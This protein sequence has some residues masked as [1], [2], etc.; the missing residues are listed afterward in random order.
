MRI[1]TAISSAQILGVFD[2][3]DE[4]KIRF[5]VEGAGPSNVIQIRARLLGQPSFT[6]LDTI[7][8][9]ENK[10]INV[11]T[12]E[13]LQIEC[14][15][16]DAISE[17]IKIYSASF[18]EAGGSAIDFIG[19]PSGSNLTDFNSFTFDSS[20]NS[21]TITGDN[22]TKTIDL[23]ANVA[24][25]G[26]TPDTPADWS[27]APTTVSEGL[28]Q[29]AE[30]MIDVEA[31]KI[32]STEKGAANGVA[33]LNALSKIDSTYLP[34]YVDD[35]EEYA[36]LAAFP[37]TGEASKI[38]VALDTNKTYRWA[39]TVYVE[40]SPSA[41]TSVNGQTGIVVLAKS[42]V[43][44]GNVDNT[45]DADK[46][47]STATQDALDLKY[48][49][50]NPAGY[51]TL[52]EV[53]AAP[54]TSVNS[55]VG[56][57]VL[58]KSDVGLGNVDNTSDADKPISTATQT[59]LDDKVAKAGDTMTGQL[60]MQDSAIVVDYTATSGFA[61]TTELGNNYV[62]LLSNNGIDSKELNQT[63]STST[64]NR[65]N[66]AS[67]TS[68]ANIILSVEESAPYLFAQTTDY[69][70]D[71]FSQTTMTSQNIA[72]D[73]ADN[74]SGVN[75]TV[76]FG[77]GAYSIQTTQ[78]DSSYVLIEGSNSGTA[79]TQ[80]DG[81]NT[82]PLMPTLPEHYTVKEYVDNLVS[83]G[84]TGIIE[85]FEVMKEPTGFID[86]TSS[87][88]SFSD[89]T[90]EFTIAP[91][92]T[93]YDVYVQGDKFTKSTS[94]TITLD[95]LS[96][97]HYI[98]FNSLGNLASTQVINSDLFQN[99][100]LVSVVYWNADTSSHSYFAEERHGLTMDGA[101]HSYLHT[102]FGARYLSGL[103]LQGFT[104]DGNGNSDTHAQF[105]SDSGSIRDEDLLITMGSQSQIPV[106]YRQ[107]L[108]WRKKAAD[109]FPIIYSGTAGY[110]GA[111]GRL[112]YNEFTGGAWQLTEV[113]N[114]GFVLVHFFG[115]NDRETPVVAIQGI[116]TYGN[117][118]AARLAASSEITSLS[119]LP[120]AEFVAIGS[121]VF[122]SADGYTNIPQAIVRSVN[123]G[124]YVD[125]RGTQLY[126][127]AGEPS[128]HSLL[129]NLSSDDHL[130]YHT[131]ARGDI[132]YY[133]KTQIDTDV[134]KKAG[135][136]AFTG[137]QSM[138][139]NKLTNLANP[140]SLTD[141]VN[142]Q[143]LNS[144]IGSTGDIFEKSFSL[145]NNQ[146][147]A[148][149]ITDFVFANGTVRSFEA[150]VSVAISATAN[151]Y[152]TFEI[153]G[154]Q[155]DS[156]WFISLSSEGDNSNVILSITS[157]G[158]FQY[159]TPNYAGFTS[160]VLKFRAITTSI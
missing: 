158:Q 63:A 123:G 142:L 36:N 45:S 55:Q 42:D 54:V 5:I 109:S 41:V 106:L 34:S 134:I 32:S 98:Y 156:D 86:R 59:A 72:I 13:E 154:I 153:K 151:L 26:Y 48:D 157:S 33:P 92:A 1:N 160:G 130:Q 103:A 105:T 70:N 101:T 15:T 141:A 83:G 20:D 128:T 91:T 25:A 159:T 71:T 97:N 66:T 80:Y 67:T 100:A 114:N 46:P 38:Y 58:T 73:F 113:A 65:T 77:T 56:D 44:L 31:N 69:A 126:T 62:L 50:S 85:R 94:L 107:G 2:V 132:R 61:T 23:V 144:A 24:T 47:I 10:V 37:P 135:T 138:G 148:A 7:N 22:T 124:D 150:L 53:P 64:L 4:S 99:N 12:Y 102:V 139:G 14:T 57:V 8:G 119:G 108:L 110:T 88:I 117:V 146:A 30:R 118:T 125:F 143:T 68:D 29:L 52:G 147:V 43:G 35:V 21:V 28:D 75:S 40:I 136:T 3:N 89:I 78:P 145:L 115:T 19:V 121:V 111:S 140:V 79:A 87:T 96:G 116:A 74:A 131:D 82:T 51:I 76:I 16:F 60:T 18:N 133:T 120:F 129:S 27:P 11:F 9:S 90:R 93:S 6:L 127:P 149:N 17:E 39:T 137:D 81:V 95:N 112:P 104:V 84:E 49:S 122:E 155:K 152:E